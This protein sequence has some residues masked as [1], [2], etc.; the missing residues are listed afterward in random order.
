MGRLSLWFGTVFRL[1][2]LTQQCEVERL[3]ADL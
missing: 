3:V 1:E 2:D